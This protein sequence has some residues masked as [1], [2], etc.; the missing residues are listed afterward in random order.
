MTWRRTKKAIKSNK[1]STAEMQAFA[2]ASVRMAEGAR[3][4]GEAGRRLRESIER[5]TQPK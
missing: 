4:L 3:M 1:L 2:D 5:T